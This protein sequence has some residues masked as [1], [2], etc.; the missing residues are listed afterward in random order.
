MAVQHETAFASRFFRY[1]RA[2]AGYTIGE[3]SKRTQDSRLGLAA[4]RLLAH[5][6]LEGCVLRG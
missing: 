1:F 4:D 2:P 6:D 5:N 3:G